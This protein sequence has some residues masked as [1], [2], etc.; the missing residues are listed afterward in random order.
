MGSQT[1]GSSFYSPGLSMVMWNGESPLQVNSPPAR[2]TSWRPSQSPSVRAS[3]SN[4]LPLFRNLYWK[5]YLSAQPQRWVQKKVPFSQ[6]FS[7]EG[8]AIPLSFRSL[9][10]LINRGFFW[11]SGYF[12]DTLR[13]QYSNAYLTHG[14]S[15]PNAPSSEIQNYA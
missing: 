8:Q 2:W 15:A 13:G 6:Y 4:V 12:T 5:A 7:A 10:R 1:A 3:S 11:L 9:L 14:I